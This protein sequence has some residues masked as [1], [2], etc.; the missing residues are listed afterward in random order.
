[1]CKKR[2][3]TQTGRGFPD[4]EKV[5]KFCSADFSQ[6]AQKVRKTGMKKGTV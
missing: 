6:S 5:R 3:Q 1:L 2:P 4:F